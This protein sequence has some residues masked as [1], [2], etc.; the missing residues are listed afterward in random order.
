MWGLRLVLLFTA[1]LAAGGCTHVTANTN[2]LYLAQ[3]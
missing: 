1:T 2:Q 3:D